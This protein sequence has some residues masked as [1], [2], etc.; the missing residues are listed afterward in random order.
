[1]RDMTAHLTQVEARE[2]QRSTSL[3]NRTGTIIAINLE[4]EQNYDH[5]NV[6]S[7]RVANKVSYNNVSYKISERVRDSAKCVE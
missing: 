3:S 7:A 5:F 2:N 6:D 4:K 1:M